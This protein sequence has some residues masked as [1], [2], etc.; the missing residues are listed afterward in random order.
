MDGN[1]EIGWEFEEGKGKGCGGNDWATSTRLVDRTFADALASSSF[2]GTSACGM[3]GLWCTA[4]ATRFPNAEVVGVD[5]YP[6]SL[7]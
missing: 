3:D 7:E 2:P 6:V 5:L 1:G 4:M